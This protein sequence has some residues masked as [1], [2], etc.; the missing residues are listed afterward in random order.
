M[1]V[2]LSTIDLNLNYAFSHAE[3][4]RPNPGAHE[5]NDQIY[6]VSVQK[7]VFSIN[8]VGKIFSDR[9]ELYV[10]EL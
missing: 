7:V 4:L 6:I 1:I 9:F 5:K 2:N 10:L 8:K 3:T